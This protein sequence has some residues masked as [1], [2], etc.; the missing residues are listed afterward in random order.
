MADNAHRRANGRG[1]TGSDEEHGEDAARPDAR[2]AGAAQPDNA[3][4]HGAAAATASHAHARSP[5]DGATTPATITDGALEDEQRGTTP[6]RTLQ[7]LRP[8]LPVDDLPPARYVAADYAAQGTTRAP[9]AARNGGLASR[10]AA[11]DYANGAR[12]TYVPTEPLLDPPVVPSQP[13]AQFP[14]SGGPFPPRVV[15]LNFPVETTEDG[16]L[17]Q[18]DEDEERSQESGSE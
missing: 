16:V 3:A 18:G 6:A 14:R 13:V 15:R 12:R 9:G 17:T 2:A 5:N 7:P 1:S 4:G 10:P 11:R 8:P